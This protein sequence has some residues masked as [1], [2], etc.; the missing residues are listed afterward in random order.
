MAQFN[1]DAVMA[2][3]QKPL[4]ELEIKVIDCQPKVWDE[5]D[6]MFEELKRKY[7]KGGGQGLRA[8]LASTLVGARL[9]V[10]FDWDDV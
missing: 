4:P 5:V 7:R 8:E 2:G 6:E 10:V 1:G 9:S 3:A